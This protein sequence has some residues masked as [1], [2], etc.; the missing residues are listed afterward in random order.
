M[1]RQKG[2]YLLMERLEKQGRERN[3]KRQQ[4]GFQRLLNIWR[5]GRAFPEGS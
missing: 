1:A 4:G 2:T 3:L 5:E